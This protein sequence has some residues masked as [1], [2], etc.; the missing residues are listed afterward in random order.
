MSGTVRREDLEAKLREIE[1]VV[2]GVEEEA[3]SR[4]RLVAV[5]VAV[6][7]VALVAYTMWRRRHRQVRVEIFYER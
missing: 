3:R 5:G 1:E 4:G 2:T 7:V 6:A